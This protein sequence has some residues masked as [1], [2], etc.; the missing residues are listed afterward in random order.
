MLRPSPLP[1]SPFSRVRLA[2]RD[3]VHVLDIARGHLS[4]LDKM[5]T[6]PSAPPSPSPCALLT[7]RLLGGFLA[8]NL[9]SGRGST[10]LEI[11]RAF[12]T[13]AKWCVP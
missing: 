3:Y 5:Q 8:Y 2:V 13:A 10:V 1:L 9:G 7:A 6:M 12:E 4:A 11:I